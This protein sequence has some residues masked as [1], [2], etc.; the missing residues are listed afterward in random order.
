MRLCVFN[1]YGI[2]TGNKIWVSNLAA[3]FKGKMKH[4]TL[5]WLWRGEYHRA[6]LEREPAENRKELFFNLTPLKKDKA[7]ATR[8]LLSQKPFPRGTNVTKYAQIWGCRNLVLL[9]DGD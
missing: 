7:K 2:S 8:K 1:P 5:T 4:K 9:L 6:I 3:A